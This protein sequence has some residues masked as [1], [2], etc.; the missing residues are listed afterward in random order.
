MH[1]AV[2]PV[3]RLAT[4]SFRSEKNQENACVRFVAGPGMGYGAVIAPLL[5]HAEAT[6]MRAACV[7][8]CYA[9]ERGPVW[10]TPAAAVTRL[11]L[12]SNAIGNA[13]AIALAAQLQVH[14]FVGWLCL[15]CGMC[16]VFILERV[17]LLRLQ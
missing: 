5:C 1:I 17:A 4:S 7:Q 13:G 12:S 16:G 11:D 3:A 14:F 15:S 6:A 8:M 10:P 2:V 9:I